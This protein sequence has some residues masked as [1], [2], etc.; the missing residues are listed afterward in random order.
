MSDFYTFDLPNY[1]QSVVNSSANVKTAAASEYL[2]AFISARMAD[3]LV[4]RQED[5]YFT[6][7][8]SARLSW[9]GDREGGNYLT[10][11]LGQKIILSKRNM[12]A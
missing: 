1:R 2:P 9:P 3:L 10:H 6:H 12:T 8:H 4:D 5:N 11:F 7:L